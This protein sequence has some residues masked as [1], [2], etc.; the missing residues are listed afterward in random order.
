MIELKSI[1]KQNNQEEEYPPRW[2]YKKHAFPNGKKSYWIKFK[3]WPGDQKFFCAPKVLTIKFDKELNQYGN[4][5]ISVFNDW[6]VTKLSYS[7]NLPKLCEEL[8]F[9]EALYDTDHELITSLFRIK[10]LIDIDTITYTLKNF[11]AFKD[12]CYKTLFTPSM[13]EKIELMVEDNYTDD[14]EAE[15]ERNMKNP[16]M[17]NIMQRKKRSLEFL[18]VHVKAILKISFAI[19]ILSFIINHFIVMRSLNLQKNIDLMYEFYIDAFYIFNFE[20]DIF[21]KLYS[22]SENKVSSSFSYNKAIFE[23]QEIK[24]SVS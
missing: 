14:I 8:N 15:N 5:N 11:N 7:T 18:N 6:K 10:H 12:M 24:N 23:Q 21:N 9:F 22:Y 3:L 13:L 1:Q 17:A 20:F 19:K 4:D 2:S 16:D